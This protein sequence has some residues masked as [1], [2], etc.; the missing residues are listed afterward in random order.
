MGIYARYIGD[1]ID[2]FAFSSLV[3]YVY[4]ILLIRKFT[5]KKI[6]WFLFFEVLITIA[7]IAILVL[8]RSTNLLDFIFTG[9]ILVSI[10][11]FIFACFK[12]VR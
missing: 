12:R 1:C 8:I 11:G 10:G 5:F 6:I 4:S 3:A 2:G 7:L 9:P